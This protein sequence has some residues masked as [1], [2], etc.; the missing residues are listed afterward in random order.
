MSAQPA[1]IYPPEAVNALR[2]LLVQLDPDANLRIDEDTG[3]LM[4]SGEF[5]ATQLQAAITSAGL[6]LRVSEPGG[7]CCGSC[8]CG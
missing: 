6:N 2:A 3:E 7:G 5:D 1:S 8:G 4:V